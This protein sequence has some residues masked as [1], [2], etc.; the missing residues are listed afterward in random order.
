MPYKD[1]N[2]ERMAK[3]EWARKNRARKKLAAQKTRAK[4]PPPSDPVGE[5]VKWS[6]AKLIVPPGHALAG[7]PM[8]IPPFAV[9]F[10]RA[11]WAAH[12]S[13]LCVARKNAKSAICAVLVL[14]HLCGPVRVDGWRGAVCSV[15]V[16]KA[17]E[18]RAQVADIAESSGLLDEIRIRKSPY[19]GIIESSTGQFEVLSAD[20]SAG[21]AS[22]FD[23]VLVD[24]T[25]LFAERDR[26]LLAGLRSSISAKGGRISHISIRGDSPLFREILENPAN[27]VHVYESDPDCELTDRQA[28]RAANPTLGTIKSMQYMIDEVNRVANVPGDENHFRAFDLNQAVDPTREMIF[29]PGDLKQCF[30]VAE[31]MRSGP[32]V[33]GFDFGESSSA[34]ACAVVWP[35]SG[36]C[37]FYMAFGDN[38][39]L[40]TRGKLDNSNY[41]LMHRRGELWT[42]PGRVT[43]VPRFLAD[44]ADRLEGQ[45]VIQGGADRYKMAEVK[46][47]LDEAKIR[48]PMDFRIV[49]AGRSGGE[50]IRRCQRLILDGKLWTHE[51]LA[52]STAIAKSQIRRDENG[53]PGL[54]RAHRRGRIDMLSSFVI[55]AGL[56]E[57]LVNKPAKPKMR[58][59]LA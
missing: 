47:W 58:F 17:A 18:L 49:G 35:A 57:P 11:S 21:H 52:L 34:T 15:S 43:P 16:N 4:Q 3:R 44:V 59:A 1:K 9:D 48:W 39:D 33:V 53:N 10:L 38:P 56:A 12:E 2:A 28:W 23:L 29:T 46:D 41:E 7:Q 36:W 5:I 6:A 22:G 19:P 37:E 55:A 40:V 42:Y 30:K 24:E 26:E 32:C 20:R 50:D 25:G 51:N 31:P 54:A 27:V 13:A 8:T 45:R 14:A